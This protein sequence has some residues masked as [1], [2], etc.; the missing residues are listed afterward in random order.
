MMA[1]SSRRRHEVGSRSPHRRPAAG[2]KMP[3]EG[4]ARG[5]LPADFD[6]AVTVLPGRH[7]RSPRRITAVTGA[8]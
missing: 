4:P 3:A 1:I 5:L 8:S 2:G 6:E 7:D